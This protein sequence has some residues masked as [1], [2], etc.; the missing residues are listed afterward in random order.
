LVIRNS[1]IMTGVFD[2]ATVGD[3]K[4]NSVFGVMLRDYGPTVAAVAMNRL[5]KVSARWLANIGF[6]IGINDVT[7]SMMLVNTKERMVQEAYDV[8]DDYINQAKL[9]KLENLPGSTQEGTLETKISGTL[10]AV[11]AA[12]GDICMRELS[13]HNAPLIM[14]TCGSKG[15]SICFVDSQHDG[16]T[17]WSYRF[18]HQCRSDGSVGRTTNHRW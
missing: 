9:G 6:S 16:L 3:G 7:P 18:R 14:A 2:K 15:E 4:K 8:C 13:R 1:E 17:L 10:S 12:V 5:A 11:R